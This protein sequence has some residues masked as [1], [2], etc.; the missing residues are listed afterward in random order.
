[1][2]MQAV[3]KAGGV[4]AAILIILNILGLIPC[5]GCITLVLSLAAYVGIGMLAAHWMM[6]PR[7]ARSAA[8]N[9]AIAAAAA[10]LIGGLVNLVV[11]GLYAAISGATQLSQISPG[12]LQ[13][14]YDLGIDPAVLAGP[15]AAVGIS[16][17]C[18]TIFL[19]IA[20][21]L[22]AAGGAFWGSRHT[23]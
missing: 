6:L 21:G 5:V 11:V 20:A 15:V 12:Q 14:L 19:F 2:D 8:T 10:A 16:A 22:G 13:T 4:G 3:L 1:M 9:G 17:F 7:T 18:C 23:T